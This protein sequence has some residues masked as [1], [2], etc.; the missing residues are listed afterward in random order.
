MSCISIAETSTQLEL[1]YNRWKIL[2]SEGLL[3][4]DWIGLVDMV[5]DIGGMVTAAHFVKQAWEARKHDPPQRLPL[6]WGVVRWERASWKSTDVVTTHRELIKGALPCGARSSIRPPLIREGEGLLPPLPDVIELPVPPGEPETQ[7]RS[8]WVGRRCS[9]GVIR[10]QIVRSERSGKDSKRPCRKPRRGRFADIHP[11]LSA[12][13]SPASESSTSSSSSSSSSSSESSSSSASS[14][15]PPLS[16]PPPS[17]PIQ[18]PY[19]DLCLPSDTEVDESDN[20]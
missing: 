3:P 11:E 14:S 20:E 1:I 16:L 19:I 18:F 10:Q 5:F 12:P 7:Q 9:D 2:I 6:H 13:S 17:N 8:S 15:F 4:S